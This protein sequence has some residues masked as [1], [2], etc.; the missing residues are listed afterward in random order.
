MIRLKV[1]I[2]SVQKELR[3]E[4]IAIGSFLSTDDF[5]REC[6]TPR[7][8]EKYPQPLRPNPKAYLE[9]LRQCQLYLLIIGSEYGA[10]A[11]EGLS[12]THEEYLLAQQMQLPTLV[13]VKGQDQN[14]EKKEAAFFQEISDAHHTYSRFETE[15]QLLEIVGKRLREHIETT[16]AV[17]PRRAQI[18]QSELNRQSA[19]PF[20]REPLDGFNYEDLDTDLALE[21]VANAED[22]D[23]E[24][25]DPNELPRLLLSR[26]YLWKDDGLLRPTIAGALLLV[27]KPGN[28][29]SQARVQMDA[30][31]GITRNADALDSTI[32]DAPLA[33]MVEAAVVFIRRNTAT[34]LVVK[35]LKR[36]KVETYPAEVLREA[37]VNA[38]AHRD[39][40]DSG[41]K[42]SIEVFADRL[43]ISS[44][45]HPPGG[46]S[47]ERLASGEA[48]SRSRNP[49]V[50]QGLAWLELMDERGSGIPRMT[51]LLEQAG[52]P[53]PQFRL[54][55]DC[56]VVELYPSMNNSGSLSEA[57]FPSVPA[58]TV[59]SLSYKEAI[60]NEAKTSGWISTKVCVQRLGIPRATAQR[61]LKELVSADK[62]SVF[63]TG[64]A[65]R[66]RLIDEAV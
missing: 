31:P 22:R 29:L 63:G 48:R 5:L 51:R 54:D 58:R 33:K 13:C 1:F 23:R 19:S 46:Q 66:Y 15:E 47:I 4:R 16:F 64:P 52:H 3:A 38:L 34:P 14:R 17:E 53:R 49:L 65:T 35:G 24:Q 28:T 59:E 37:V 12:A 25:V 61:I 43:V 50:V 44:P 56:L 41:A 2:S 18:E 21:M 30:F 27:R 42:I 9:L 60:I 55:H 32:L 26:S 8:F 20:E 6:I 7:I 45:G 11:G 62:L 40:A 57:S 36:Q 10:D 39:Y